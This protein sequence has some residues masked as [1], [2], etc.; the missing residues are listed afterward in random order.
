MSH[1][2]GVAYRVTALSV[3]NN[4]F[5]LFPCHLVGYQY[6]LFGVKS[7]PEYKYYMPSSLAL[8]G[9]QCFDVWGEA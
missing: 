2:V 4:L 6:L 3:I 5:V 8:T 1:V 9:R 7:H